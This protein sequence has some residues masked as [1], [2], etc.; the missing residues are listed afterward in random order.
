MC[1]ESNQI[2]IK[3]SRRIKVEDSIFKTFNEEILKCIRKENLKMG[4]LNI[5]YL[6]NQKNKSTRQLEA[7]LWWTKNKCNANWIHALKERKSTYGNT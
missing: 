7:N 3:E 6:N 2:K 5:I 4:K 1:N